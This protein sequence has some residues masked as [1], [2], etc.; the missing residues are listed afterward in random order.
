VGSITIYDSPTFGK[1]NRNPNHRYAMQPI[2]LKIVNADDF[3]DYLNGLTP[4]Y[5]LKENILNLG[6]LGT[7]TEPLL[8]T[9]IGKITGTAKMLKT[10]QGKTFPYF[11]DVKSIS[12]Q[13]QM[14][15]DKAPA[16][17]LRSLE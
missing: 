8:S 11:Q 15:I 14:Y 12:G 9:A 1:E 5:A 3:G 6:V 13:N 7:N 4:T 17:L 10:T 2:V 16:G